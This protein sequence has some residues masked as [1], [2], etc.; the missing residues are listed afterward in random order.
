[1]KHHDVLVLNKN[2]APVHII[3]WQ[4]CMCLL[5]KDHAHA[6]DREFLAYT[7]DDWAKFSRKC[8][9][10]Y[11]KVNSVSCSIAIPEIIVLLYYNRL[12]MREVKFSRQSVFA[13]DKYICQYC[14]KMFGKDDL[15]IDHILPRS[16]GGLTVWDNIVTCCMDCNARKADR[17]LL[18]VR[19][20]YPQD[21]NRWYL[22]RK[23]IKPKW[24]NP[25]SNHASKVHI[26]KTWEHFMKKIDTNDSEESTG[27]Q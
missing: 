20:R 1:M 15:T 8:L 11:E 27:V 2:Y 9:S 6:L 19:E 17:T 25:V 10:D 5:M 14:K 4:K 13:R 22:P 23:P 18:E 16:K 12:P 3:T 7:F 26:C 24:V 21:G